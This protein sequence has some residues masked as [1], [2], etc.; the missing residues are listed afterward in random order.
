MADMNELAERIRAMR[1]A[2]GLNVV[3]TDKDSGQ[4]KL[5]SFASAASRDSFIAR[6]VHQGHGATIDQGKGV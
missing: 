4:T 2:K 5:L 6:A 3:F 1:M